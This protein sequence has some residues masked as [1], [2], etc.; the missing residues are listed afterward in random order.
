MPESLVRTE[1]DPTGDR[2]L[3]LALRDP[4]G[5]AARGLA[6]YLRAEEA[7]RNSPLR[8]LLPG[9]L[10]I[11]APN[12][13]IQLSERAVN[14]LLRVGAGSLRALA[15]MTPDELRQVP[16]LGTKTVSEILAAVLSEW[17]TAYLGGDEDDQPV[18]LQHP[19][20]APDAL[21]VRRLL[22]AFDEIEGATGF[23]AF[24]RRKLDPD[25][26]LSQ[27]E[28]AAALGLKPVQLPHY[29]KAI[30]EKLERQMRDADSSLSTAVAA[31]KDG[32]G[33]L[34][35]R[36][37]LD[38]TLAVID[39][40]ERAISKDAPQRLA[41]LLLLAGLRVT[42]DW[43]IDVEIEEIMDAL[44]GGLTESGPASLDVI[45]RLLG[46]LGVRSDLRLPWVVS[47]LGYRVMEQSLRRVDDD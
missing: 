46:R 21:D 9:L 1:P 2:V 18:D 28:I 43:V 36:V 37:D 4:A 35:R 15:P 47:R 23:E 12:F 41:L 38:R 39:P 32:V 3:L 17:A 45:D 33:V 16:R 27:S 24:R 20:A 34:A 6:E 30:S 8:E 19:A 40:F 10:L 7:C 42:D 11:D 13:T 22:D 26:S 31:L 29:E 14:P 25:E 44:L 5:A